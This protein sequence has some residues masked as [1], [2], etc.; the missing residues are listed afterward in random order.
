MAQSGYTPI[1]LYYSTTASA[2]PTAGNLVN[3]E[4]AINITDGKLYYKD[5]G[6]TVR[7]LASQ[8]DLTTISF[9]TTGL[10]PSTATGGAVTVAGTLSVANG[11]TGQTTYTN[12]QLLIGNTTGN[13]L[14]KATLT[15]GSGVTITNGSGSITISATGSGGDAVLAN[16]NAFTGAN[17]FY[18]GT[19]QTFGTATSTQDGLI[20]AGRAGGSSSF[21]VTMQPGTLTASRTA[22]FPDETFT[23]GFRNIPAGSDKTSNYSLLTSDV[24]KVIGVGTGGSI[25]IPDS[26][27]SAGDAVIIFNNTTAGIT[28]TCTITTAYIAGTDTDKATMTLATRGIASILF[29]SGTVCVVSGNVT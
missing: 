3:G 25:T 12:G 7:T 19:G 22:T 9:G 17:T 26:T 21:R 5:N 15:A 2:A 24:G 20:L 6:G 11:G 28:I 27:F 23:V 8:S 18:N 4:L 29:V 16:N 14:T 1:Q 13:T 10:T